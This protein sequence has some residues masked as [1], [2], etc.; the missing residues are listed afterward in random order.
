MNDIFAQP[1]TT[2]MRTNR[3]T[4][5]R[6][7]EQN[8]QDFID[9]GKSTTVNLNDID[10]VCLQQLF[11]D[12]SV[13]GVFAGSDADSVRLQSFT[14]GCVTENVVRSRRLLDKPVELHP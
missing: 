14:D 3:H 4:E 12:H 1:Y 8:A 2:S 7:H 10:R 6:S 13:V 9:T 5:L 11:E